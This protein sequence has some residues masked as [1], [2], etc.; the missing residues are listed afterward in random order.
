MTRQLLLF[1]FSCLWS[2]LGAQGFVSPVSI[3]SS[4]DV[5]ESGEAT[6]TF[7]ADIADGWHLYSTEAMSGPTQASLTL[8]TLKGARLKGPLRPASAAQKQYEEMFGSEVFFFEQRAVFLQTVELTGGPYELTGYLTY[9]AC[10]N[11]SCTPPTD[12]EFSFKGDFTANNQPEELAKQPDSPDAVADPDSLPS[13]A[14]AAVKADSIA[15]APLPLPQQ[16]EGHPLLWLFLLGFAGGLVALF[17][18]CVWPVIPLTVSFFLKRGAGGRKGVHAA[19]LYGAAIVIIYVSL[20]LAVTAAFGASALN[21]LATNAFF[22]ILFFLMLVLF[23]VSFIGGFDLSL[24]SSW[25]GSVDSKASRTTGFLSIFLMAFTLVLVSFSCTGPIIGF[26]LVEV[27]TADIAG[28]V[29]GMLGF[30]LA[31]ALP[32]TLF[33][34]F[35][36]WLKAAPKSGSW[37]HTVKVT[38]GY[39]ELAFSLKF[40]SVAD[41]AYGWGILPRW[42]FIA[43]W[44]ALALALT[45]QLLFTQEGARP[46]RYSLAALALAFAGYMTPGLW[47]A[48]LRAVSAFTPPMEETG[49]VIDDFEAGLALAK[50]EGKRVFIDFTGYGCVNCRKMEATVF[51]DERIRRVLER[52]YIFVRLY[53]DDKTKLT[54]PLRVEQSGKQRTLRTVGDRWSFLQATRF[55]AQTQP[56]YVILDAAGTQLAPPRSYDEDADAFLRWL[57]TGR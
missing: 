47:G 46:L 42:L 57:Q 23:G 20:G 38:L 6:L 24:P 54:E 26:L 17:T 12:E 11:V 15:A 41:M 55:G 14:P 22:N 51:Q 53:V 8:E 2:A 13:P 3:S 49:H 18:P 50:G 48:P 32:F 9:G 21:D 29:V 37:M 31:L 45:L 16:S 7:E 34:L 40:L 10:N 43:L 5:A 19:L 36:G 33:A 56:F 35:P 1:F 52:D 27:V 44:I 28:P 30:S 39:V 4:I 25:A